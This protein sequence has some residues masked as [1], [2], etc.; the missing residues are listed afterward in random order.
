MMLF[1]LE[2]VPFVMIRDR[3]LSGFAS[4]LSP[5]LTICVSDESKLCDVIFPSARDVFFKTI[6]KYAMSFF[7]VLCQCLAYLYMCTYFLTNF[8]FSS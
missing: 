4:L 2:D 8:L 1:Q 5:T 6:L 3:V 7:S